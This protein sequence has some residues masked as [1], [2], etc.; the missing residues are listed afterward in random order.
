MTDSLVQ[1]N[2]II[3]TILHLMVRTLYITKKEPAQ[4]PGHGSA[5]ST[6]AKAVWVFLAVGCLRAGNTHGCLSQG[7]TL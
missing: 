2:E 4:C 6:E 7:A 1:A 5:I 3:G